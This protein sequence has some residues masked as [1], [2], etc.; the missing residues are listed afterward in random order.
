MFK[1]QTHHVIV[2]FCKQNQHTIYCDFTIEM[3]HNRSVEHLQQKLVRLVA[4]AAIC[5]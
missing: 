3:M 1:K 5:H 4:K 2:S